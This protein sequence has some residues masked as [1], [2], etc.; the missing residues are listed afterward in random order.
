[1]IDNGWIKVYRKLMQKGYYKRSQYIHLWVHILLCAS[2]AETEF[3]WNGKM[4][5][6]MPGQFVT[7]RNSLSS[8]TGIP[9][10]TVEDILKL[11]EREQQI[12]QLKNNRFRLLT[13]LNWNEMQGVRQQIRQLA[14]SQPTASRH[15][16][17]TFKNIKNEKNERNKNSIPP[18][19]DEVREY[20]KSKNYSVDS[21][22]WYDHYESRG[23]MAGKTKMKDWQAGI[24]T[25]THGNSFEKKP[26]AN[27]IGA[28]TT[29]ITEPTTEERI[30]HW[31]GKLDQA[32]ACS[33]DRT[34]DEKLRKQY[35]LSIPIYEREIAALHGE[36][37]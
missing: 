29:P 34:L 2:H 4:E 18:T 6:L 5:K 25:W 9:P 24:R 15:L 33:T 32:I 17:D 28:N 19:L 10:S 37:E 31:Q 35:L 12:R 8:D 30:Q 7:G 36:G 21:Q 11:F 27:N 1:M 26:S 23:W 3:L 16:A 13:V 22:K 14:D 20:I